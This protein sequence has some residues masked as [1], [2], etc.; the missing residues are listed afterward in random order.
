MVTVTP[1]EVPEPHGVVIDCDAVTGTENAATRQRRP[2]R[3]VSAIG[4]LAIGFKNQVKPTGAWC[5]LDRVVRDPRVT[6]SV[7]RDVPGA[8]NQAIRLVA[9]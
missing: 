2:R 8:A 5:A 9:T 1:A 4:R 6:S 3:A 7:E